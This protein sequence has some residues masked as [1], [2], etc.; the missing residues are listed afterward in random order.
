MNNPS[1]LYIFGKQKIYVSGNEIE[2]KNQNMI[3]ECA[4]CPDVIYKAIV[5]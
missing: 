3:P 1:V 4:I 2:N 5:N